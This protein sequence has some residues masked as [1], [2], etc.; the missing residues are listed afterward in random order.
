MRQRPKDIEAIRNADIQELGPDAQMNRGEGRRGQF[1][2][3][4]SV[5]QGVSVLCMEMWQDVKTHD[6]Q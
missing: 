4:F 6:N 3:F 1:Y 2:S 5:K